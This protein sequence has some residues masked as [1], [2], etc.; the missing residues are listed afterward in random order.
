M[1]FHC[2]AFH[3]WAYLLEL[4]VIGHIYLPVSTIDW[5]RCDGTYSF[6]SAQLLPPLDRDYV[7]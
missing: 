6:L 2:G 7:L 1:T 3:L 4:F 5:L